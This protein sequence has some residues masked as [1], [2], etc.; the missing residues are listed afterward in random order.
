V[1][2]RLALVRSSP[3]HDKCNA[4]AVRSAA[5]V[6]RRV[7]RPLSTRGTGSLRMMGTAPGAVG[8][9]LER[10]PDRSA[11]VR[12]AYPRIVPPRDVAALG[13][14]HRAFEHSIG[15][16]HGCI[17]D[18]GGRR[19]TPSVLTERD[20]QHASTPAELRGGEVT[21]HR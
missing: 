9:R 10:V 12:S 5:L 19:E 4:Q 15:G 6:P 2:H 14:A 18:Y 7:R 17:H 8:I 13:T 21:R 1:S 11:P 20:P 16:S 3:R